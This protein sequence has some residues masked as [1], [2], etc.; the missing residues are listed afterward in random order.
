MV[1][2]RGESGFGQQALT[3]SALPAL[4]RNSNHIQL[5]FADSEEAV[6]DVRS[7][8]VREHINGLWVIHIEATSSDPDLPFEKFV[9]RGAGLSLNR[10]G[11]DTG[12]RLWTGIC[13]QLTHR[14][15]AG[16]GSAAAP[17]AIAQVLGG[18]QQGGLS[19]YSLQIVPELWRLTLRR[20]S[21]IFQH[22]SLPEI[23]VHLLKDWGIE[24]PANLLL[25]NFKLDEKED[26]KR[27]GFSRFPKL[28]YR[29]QYEETDFEF[30]CRVLE[31]AGIAFYFEYDNK[32]EG[33]GRERTKLVL[34]SDAEQARDRKSESSSGSAGSGSSGGADSKK[35]DDAVAKWLVGP[36]PYLGE[37]SA[38]EFGLNG[39]FVTNA[40][41]AR[42][43]RP[44]AVTLIDHDFRHALGSRAGQT[45]QVQGASSGNSSQSSEPPEAK[46]ELFSYTPGRLQYERDP[47]NGNEYVEDRRAGQATDLLRAVRTGDL[48]LSFDSNVLEIAPGSVV[49]FGS[50]PEAEGSVSPALGIGGADEHP[51]AELSGKRRHLVIETRIS[52]DTMGKWAVRCVA[53][54]AGQ[55]YR[56]PQNTPKPRILGV[57]SALIVGEKTSQKEQIYCDPSGR[58]RVQFHWDRQHHFGEPL[59][60]EAGRNLDV[61]GSCW[62]RVS[63]PWAGS[64]YGF[65]A[66]P[67][68][69]HEVLVSFLDGDPDQPMIVGSL[70]NGPNP[71]PYPG[72]KTRTGIKS[73]SSPD[74]GGFNEMY[75]DDA[76]GREQIHF[77]AQN[78]MSTVVKGQESHSVGGSRI[79]QIGGADTLHVGQKW[80]LAVGKTQTGITADQGSVITL[81]VGGAGGAQIQLSGPNVFI[82][83]KSE[84][85]LHALKDI[86]LS[87]QGQI[88]ID[89]GNKVNL[90]CGTPDAV[91][92][93]KYA[94]ASAP[95]PGSSIAAGPKP[96]GGGGMPNAPG[97]IIADVDFHEP[98]PEQKNPAAPQGEGEGEGASYTRGMSFEDYK[99][100]VYDPAHQPA[101]VAA[102]LDPRITSGLER[103][104]A[105]AVTAKLSGGSVLTGAMGGIAQ[106][107]INDAITDLAPGAGGLAHQAATVG[108]GALTGKASGA[109]I[110]GSL[111]GTAAQVGIGAVAPSSG[112]GIGGAVGSVAT[113]VAAGAATK[114]VSGAASAAVAKV[115]GPSAAAHAAAPPAPQQPAPPPMVSPPP[116]GSATTP[117]A[118]PPAPVQ[119]HPAP[120]PAPGQPAPGQ[121][122]PA[123]PPPG[124]EPS[125]PNDPGMV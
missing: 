12:V 89:G 114:A 74:G 84:I 100:N 116:Q 124:T 123:S 62:V 44:G 2:Q 18:A 81:Q 67:R 11:T 55:P 88:R 22:A 86:H 17:G 32:R 40:S 37:H 16:A 59:S 60:G 87:A 102:G 38:P 105:G 92:L 99:K 9:D 82:N 96:E 97:P 41:A 3:A 76:K 79:T 21:R 5:W 14:S 78:S 50:D 29:V 42:Q 7:F 68:V 25:R 72:A 71:Q 80:E 91:S 23:A 106:E 69:G 52:G 83:A 49:M 26:E 66:I 56:P 51:R 19:Q 65:V 122:Q 120:A 107:G 54:D 73:N 98:P 47:A 35:D 77:Q 94:T 30:F 1:A 45:V 119:G 75:F 115:T 39:G 117:Q 113:S 90:N 111:A 48:L 118:A 110:A 109:S 103:V 63:T 34:D 64:A 13:S 33:K 104:V 108:I 61:L 10:G 28:E 101:A 46:Y 6:L 36:L 85:H 4:G 43:V 27:R 57:Q 20:N 58:V 121:G 24:A 53:V 93:S 70:Y 112:G 125:D 15:A 95:S 8:E 31:E